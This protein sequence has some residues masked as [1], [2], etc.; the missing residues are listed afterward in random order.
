MEIA[1]VGD[2]QDHKVYQIT[3]NDVLNFEAEARCSNLIG[4]D[5][6]GVKF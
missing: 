5:S 4:L 2:S 1:T 3:F 6:C